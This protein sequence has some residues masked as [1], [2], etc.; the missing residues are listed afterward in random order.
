MIVNFQYIYNLLLF[1]LLYEI[2][3]W[4]PKYLMRCGASKVPFQAILSITNACVYHLLRCVAVYD[5]CV[6]L[7]RYRNFH[8]FQ[9]DGVFFFL[10]LQEEY[11]LTCCLPNTF[12]HNC[13]ASLE[14][15]F[16]DD[17]HRLIYWVEV[18]LLLVGCPFAHH[19]HEAI[20]EWHWDILDKRQL[21]SSFIAN[22]SAYPGS[23]WRT[24]LP[25]WIVRSTCLVKIH[26]LNSTKLQQDG[27]FAQSWYQGTSK[28]A[29]PF[30]WTPSTWVK[31]RRKKRRKCSRK[32]AN[33][34]LTPSEIGVI[35]RDSYSIAQVHSITG[36]KIPRFLNKNG[37]F[38]LHMFWYQESDVSLAWLITLGINWR[39]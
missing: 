6:N 1:Y 33:N 21:L 35:L 28:P 12:C 25:I 39:S 7:H 3:L 17:P 19:C 13:I 16:S 30:K 36:G 38:H 20:S 11:M 10:V 26:S 4:L 27:A 24:G 37:A 31:K 2:T 9:R 22:W 15:W 34:G 32:F 14:T 29:I 5:I 18:C 23:V 8:R